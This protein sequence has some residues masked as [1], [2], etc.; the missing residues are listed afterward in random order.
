MNYKNFNIRKSHGGL[1]KFSRDKLF[2]SVERT[3]LIPKK[4]EEITNKVEKEIYDGAKTREIYR[5]TLNLIKE[6]SSVAAVHYS[7]KRAI[8]E[9]GPAGHNFE[10]FV[11]R[12]FEEIGYQSK[13]TVVL[14]GKFVRHEVDV[15]ITKPNEKHFVECKFHN[16]LGIKNDIKTALYVK[17]RWD[18]LK[19]GPEGHDLSGFFLATN[20]SFT[21]DALTYAQGVGLKLLGI[22]APAEKPFIEEV[23]RMKLYPITSLRK[24]NKNL[25]NELLKNQ[26]IL[27]REIPANL[28]ILLK[29]GMKEYDI[30]EMLSQIHFLEDNT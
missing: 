18:D 14:Q 7:L 24:M 4:C 11:A 19:D 12:Y 10:L 3:G 15:I 8:F 2:H 20:T 29:F 9:L 26:V 23:K 5:R 27:A 25:K 22:N 17:A 21:L 16:K 28:H 30:E 6:S 1:E 13:T